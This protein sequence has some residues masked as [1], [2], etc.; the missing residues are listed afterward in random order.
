MYLFLR[1][2]LKYTNEWLGFVIFTVVKKKTL[3]Y[4]YVILKD[5]TFLSLPSSLFIM[6]LNLFLVLS[7]C[8]KRLLLATQENSYINVFNY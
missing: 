2:S 1:V 3:L 5:V 7:L 4:K 8:G 6:K